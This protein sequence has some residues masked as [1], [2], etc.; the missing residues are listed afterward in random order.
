M[1]D[2]RPVL[3]YRERLL[4]ASEPFITAQAERLE[5]HR[6]WYLGLRRADGHPVP[7]ERDLRWADAAAAGP[8]GRYA[9]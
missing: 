8:A 6:P 9:W 7:P 1:P 2:P 5:R 4:A 3:I